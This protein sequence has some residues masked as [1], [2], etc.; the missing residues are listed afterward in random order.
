MPRL[1]HLNGPPA[2]GKSTLAERY[3][4]DHPAL[5]RM[6]DDL[7]AV[8]RARPDAIVIETEHGAVDDAY[9]AVI[10]ALAQGS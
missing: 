8:L 6:Y 5:L 7:T 2:I 3:V 10:A 9:A 4:D 1:I